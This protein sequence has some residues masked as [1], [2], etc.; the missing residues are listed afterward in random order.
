VAIFAPDGTTGTCTRC[1]RPLEAGQSIEI[2]GMDASERPVWGHQGCT[3]ADR[4]KSRKGFFDKEIPFP[5]HTVGSE[6]MK[7]VVSPRREDDENDGSD[8]GEDTESGEGSGEDQDGED[9]IDV[10]HGDYEGGDQLNAREER[11]KLVESEDR[12]NQ[13]SRRPNG[14]GET[15]LSEPGSDSN[16]AEDDHIRRIAREVFHEEYSK[17]RLSGGEPGTT[18]TVITDRGE[19]TFPEGEFRHAAFA[20]VVELV[21]NGFPLFVPGPSGC[22]KTH[23]MKQVARALR[24]HCFGS[25]SGS[26]GTTETHFFGKS[27]PNIT[28]GH[29]RFV[30][31]QFL[32]CYEK[33]GL[34]FLDEIDAIDAN[35][36]IS[37]NSAIANGWCAVPAR[38][39]A[40]TAKMHPRFRIVASA[41]TRGSGANRQ[42]YGRNKLDES[43]MDRFRI[44]VPMDYDQALERNWACPDADL[45]SHLMKWRSAINVNQ[46]PRLLSTR[47][48]NYAYRLK[49]MGKS[50][51]YIA[52]QLCGDWSPKEQQVVFG[53]I[54]S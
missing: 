29:D 30:S 9:L 23:L 47:F 5:E 22:G 39:G 36:L 16:Q 24:F 48:V 42:Y 20:E 10:G 52:R 45:Y 37:L 28:T 13:G 3:P 27:I 49:K 19:Y 26:A 7:L 35:C 11:N 4:D 33:G 25:I 53:K 50:L 6:E 14:N 31:T 38:E 46:I 54:L 32:D 2:I 41:N 43:T 51:E 34:F 17:V 15:Q 1:Q 40:T 8:D 18:L 12:E 44:S 21:G